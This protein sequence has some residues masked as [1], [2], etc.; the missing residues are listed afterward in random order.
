MVCRRCSNAFG[1]VVFHAVG[2]DDYLREHEKARAVAESAWRERTAADAAEQKDRT[3]R[4][5]ERAAKAVVEADYARTHADEVRKTNAQS[6]TER[7]LTTW[8]ESKK[9]A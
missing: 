3:A 1:E 7:M 6:L 8:Q 4:A 9:S 2:E 5:E